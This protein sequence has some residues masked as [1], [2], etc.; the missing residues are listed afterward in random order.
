[1]SALRHV[2]RVVVRSIFAQSAQNEQ[3][4]APRGFY[5]EMELILIAIVA[6]KFNGQNTVES[7]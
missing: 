3:T 1:M 5:T 6:V 4:A 7:L 2:T